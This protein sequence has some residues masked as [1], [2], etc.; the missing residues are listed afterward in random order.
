MEVNTRWREL[1]WRHMIWELVRF[2]RSLRGKRG[3]EWLRGLERKNAITIDE[4][5]EFPVPRESV[6]LVREYLEYCRNA[7]NSG[8]SCLRDEDEA[9]A[10]CDSLGLEVGKTSTRSKEHHQSSK[11]L[12]AAVTGLAEK[13]CRRQGVPLDSN[14][15]RRV[16]WCND[17]GLHV[18]ARNLDGAVP[19]LFNPIVVWE[20]KEYWGKTSGGS[21][22]SDAVYE[23]QLVGR[24]LREFEERSGFSVAHVVFVDGRDQWGK[25]KSDLVRFL[26]LFHQGVIDF[27][28]VGSQVE[29][30]WEPVL[31]GLLSEQEAR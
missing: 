11:A 10:F 19:G 4:N 24:E 9:L 25:R 12:V 26:D 13:I 18:S 29:S 1:G 16:V 20:I 7:F 21:K 2:Y 22:M 15:Q 3:E 27:L 31:E 8:F 30:E 17:Q 5:S 23:C 28:H 14:P 6:V